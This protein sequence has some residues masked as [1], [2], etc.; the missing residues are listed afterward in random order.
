MPLCF[1]PCFRMKKNVLAMISLAVLVAGC[2]AAGSVTDSDDAA[3]DDGSSVSVMSEA[4][5][6][7]SASSVDEDAVEVEVELDAG[8]EASA[9]SSL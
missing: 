6:E 3:V 9:A 1:L 2:N 5:S 7:S 8:T 4:S